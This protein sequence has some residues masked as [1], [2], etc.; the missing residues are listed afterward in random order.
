MG[1]LTFVEYHI[2]DCAIAPIDFNFQIYDYLNLCFNSKD[3]YLYLPQSN[4]QFNTKFIK[5]LP[6]NILDINLYFLINIPYKNKKTKAIIK[7]DSKHIE[8]SVFFEF[9]IR[10]LLLDSENFEFSCKMTIDCQKLTGYDLALFT[11]EI[12]GTIHNI[13]IYKKDFE[14]NISNINLNEI[15]LFK[16]NYIHKEQNNFKWYKIND[17]KELKKKKRNFCLSFWILEFF[18]CKIYKRKRSL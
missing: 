12:E 6:N 9:Y 17:K 16:L 3:I 2:L 13:F 7:C 10:E 15:N 5:Y 14:S 1:V 4:Y 11:C 8:K 18:Y